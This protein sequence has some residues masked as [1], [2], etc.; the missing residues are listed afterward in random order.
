MSYPAA[1]FLWTILISR[2][3]DVMLLFLIVSSL[4]HDGSQKKEE[5]FVA[6]DFYH[7]RL[8]HDHSY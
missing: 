2:R 7:V 1:K 5:I 3:G 6:K 4:N 8:L